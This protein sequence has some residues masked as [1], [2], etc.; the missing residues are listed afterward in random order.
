MWSIYLCGQ[1]DPVNPSEVLITSADSRIRILNGTTI[2]QKFRGTIS[3]TLILGPVTQEVTSW[4]FVDSAIANVGFYHLLTGF[5]NTNS[6]ISASFT[7]DGK[8]VICASED[9]LVYVWKRDKLRN[10]VAWKK[11]GFVTTQS[12]E[13]FQCKDV[14]VAI[15]WPGSIK[16]EPPLLSQGSKREHCRSPSNTNQLHE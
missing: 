5:R 15:P 6:Q 3:D 10:V 14:S 13:Y 1:F 12:H 9:S 8:Y 11:K 2:V 16:Y 4:I 7:V